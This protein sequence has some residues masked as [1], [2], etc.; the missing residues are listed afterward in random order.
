MGRMLPQQEGMPH[1][2]ESQ[3]QTR[4]WNFILSTGQRTWQILHV[5][6]FLLF[7]PF[8]EPLAWAIVTFFLSKLFHS[9]G[10]QLSWAFKK[11]PC[12]L[13][14]QVT[15]I[16]STFC[17]ECCDE[18]GYTS[19]VPAFRVLLKSHPFA[20]LSQIPLRFIPK[21]LFKSFYFSDYLINKNAHLDILEPST[22][23][24]ENRLGCW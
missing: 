6:T 10:T 18:H 9:F 12:W 13:G 19:W 8:W 5:G 4:T 3:G 20:I 21:P 11:Q 17:E 7:P 1:I 16:V 22:E 14:L 15:W 23:K 2:F 24:R